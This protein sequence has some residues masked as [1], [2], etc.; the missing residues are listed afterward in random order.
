MEGIIIGQE[1]IPIIE[2][3]R[4][5][6][7]KSHSTLEGIEFADKFIKLNK[8]NHIT[9]T[10][11]L[12]LKKAERELGKNLLFERVTLEKRNYSSTGTLSSTRPSV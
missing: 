12:L 11:Y 6:L 1:S 8:H 4:E 9:T 3:I 2:E 10:Y 5:E 7:K